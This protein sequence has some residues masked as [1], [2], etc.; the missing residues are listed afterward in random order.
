MNVPE[1]KKEL[2][3][4]KKTWNDDTALRIANHL[5]H[6]TN[7]PNGKIHR[8]IFVNSVSPTNADGNNGDIWITYEG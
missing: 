8:A 3:Q 7:D 4:H 5:G 1:W 6:D 2:D